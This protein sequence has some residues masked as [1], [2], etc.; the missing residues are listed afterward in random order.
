MY[1]GDGRVDPRVVLVTS[2]YYCRVE[3]GQAGVGA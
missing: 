2:V 1:D 3:I